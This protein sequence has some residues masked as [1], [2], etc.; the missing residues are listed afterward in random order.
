MMYM[1]VRRMEQPSINACMAALPE[2]TALHRARPPG[3]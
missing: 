1:P 2:R 3:I